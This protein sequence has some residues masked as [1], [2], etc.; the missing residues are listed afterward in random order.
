MFKSLITSNSFPGADS[1]FYWCVYILVFYIFYCS[2]TEYNHCTGFLLNRLFL[3]HFPY[4]KREEDFEVL[5]RVCTCHL[6]TAKWTD[7]HA[8]F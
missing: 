1:D 6:M 4:P 5:C 7:F 8:S 3:A 2:V